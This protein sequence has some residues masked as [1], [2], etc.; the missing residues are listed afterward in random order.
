MKKTITKKLMDSLEEA[1]SLSV[2]L[3]KSL[4]SDDERMKMAFDINFRISLLLRDIGNNFRL[5]ELI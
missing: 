5:K 1:H 2:D 3:R 4:H